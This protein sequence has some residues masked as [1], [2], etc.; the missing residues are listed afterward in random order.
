MEKLQVAIA[1]KAWKVLIAVFFL[2]LVQGVNMTA[3]SL[4]VPAIKPGAEE[5]KLSLSGKVLSVERL[6]EASD[7]ISYK[8]NLS[9]TFRNQGRSAIILCEKNLWLGAASL[10]R[11]AEDAGAYKFFYDRSLWP[12]VWPAVSRAKL[13]DSFDKPAPPNDIFLILNPE[14]EWELQSAVYLEFE[15]KKSG[16]AKNAGWEEIREISPMLLQVTFGMWPV[17]VEPSLTPDDPQF[18]RKLRERW[19]TVGYLWL[20]DLTSEPIELDLKKA[21]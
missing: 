19:K 17:N 14:K 1:R 16:S 2:M 15:K 13:R 18:G 7:S 12:S 10:A 6:E 3:Q 9:L 21:Q 4:V 5:A 11:S 8:V 20:D